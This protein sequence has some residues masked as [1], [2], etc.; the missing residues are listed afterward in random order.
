MATKE[1][2]APDAE[3]KTAK[4]QEDD[5]KESL[6]ENNTQEETESN[7]EISKKGGMGTGEYL[8]VGLSLLLILV[9]VG[10]GMFLWVH[11]GASFGGQKV[12]SGLSQEV[13]CSLKPFF[14]PLVEK[15]TGPEKFLRLSLSLELHD[16]NSL[17]QVKYQNEQVRWAVLQVL[18]SA[19]ARD[20]EY[21]NG[22]RA[23]TDKIVT[24]VNRALDKEVVKGV[25]FNKVV[26]L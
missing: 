15:K 23:L 14:L 7:Q 9:V 12:T 17:K 3:L 1:G 21:A 13:T 24:S 16:K 20:L 22:K 18:M 2:E 5:Q 11:Y 8:L 19:V 26:I 6:D 10:G 25:R 4:G